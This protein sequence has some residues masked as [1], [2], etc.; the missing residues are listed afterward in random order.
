MAHRSL[1]A[2]AANRRLHALTGSVARKGVIAPIPGGR[3]H[4]FDP[5][6]LRTAKPQLHRRR[7]CVS[8][9]A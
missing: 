9:M 7:I 5:H 6:R 2:I 4:S 3:S 8:G 1:P